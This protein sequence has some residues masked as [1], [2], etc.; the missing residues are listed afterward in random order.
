MLFSLL[1]DVIYQRSLISRW[2]FTLCYKILLL[3]WEMSGT[4]SFPPVDTKIHINWDTLVSGWHLL[5]RLNSCLSETSSTASSFDKAEKHWNNRPLK[6]LQ[7]FDSMICGINWNPGSPPVPNYS[8]PLRPTAVGRFHVL[9]NVLF[10][11]I[12]YIFVFFVFF[13]ESQ[14]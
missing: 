1:R 9:A 4:R 6:W 5:R 2:A 14:K 13:A 7:N 10:W 11:S 3:L 12:K 8:V